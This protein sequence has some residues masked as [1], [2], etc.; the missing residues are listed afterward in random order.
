MYHYNNLPSIVSHKGKEILPEQ[1]PGTVKISFDTFTPF[2]QHG[3]EFMNRE[4]LDVGQNHDL[5]IVLRQ[6]L[7]CASKIEAQLRLRPLRKA[8][9]IFHLFDAGLHSKDLPS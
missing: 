5:T 9:T 2:D 1:Q 4:L 7:D 3:R 8:A 6:R